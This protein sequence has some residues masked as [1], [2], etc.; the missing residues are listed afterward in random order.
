MKALVLLKKIKLH[1][2]SSGLSVGSSGGMCGPLG[3]PPKIDFF[4]KGLTK[5]LVPWP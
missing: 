3:S 2:S 4:N 1:I 5:E